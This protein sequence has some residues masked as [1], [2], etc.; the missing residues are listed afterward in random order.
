[1]ANVIVTV[2]KDGKIAL[3]NIVSPNVDRINFMQKLESLPV[4]LQCMEYKESELKAL[5]PGGAINADK[6]SWNGNAIVYDPAK[7]NKQELRD[8]RTL[9]LRSRLLSLGLNTSDIDLLINRK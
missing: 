1:M 2:Y 7:K 9:T 4:V 3:T 5:C 8:E 6:L